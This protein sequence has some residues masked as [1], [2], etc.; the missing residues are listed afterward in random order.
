VVPSSW[1]QALATD[2]EEQCRSG[3]PGLLL[4]DEAS[5]WGPAVRHSSGSVDSRA[6]PRRVNGAGHTALPSLQ[7]RDPR[8]LVVDDEKHA[9]AL[10]D[11]LHD[12]AGQAEDRRLVGGAVS[13]DEGL[14]AIA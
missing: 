12:L 2:D 1:S 3:A 5:I 14:A 10:R 6:S 8:L 9:G 11:R 4:L 13:H 7:R